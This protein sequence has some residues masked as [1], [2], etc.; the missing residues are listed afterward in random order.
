MTSTQMRILALAAVAAALLAPRQVR[1]QQQ[2][3][4]PPS[5]Y[6]SFHR[7]GPA[8]VYWGFGWSRAV[9]SAGREFPVVS[10]VEANSPATTAG[11][12]VGDT[13][14]AVDGRDTRD[15]GPM[16]R[17]LQPGSRYVLRLRGGGA[18]REVAIVAG[19]PRSAAPT[20]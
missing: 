13:I 18:V 16:F 9:T 20:P 12:A 8:P 1:A 5:G 17:H 10:S 15:D 3:A 14:L 11:L 6:P 19:P 2:S 7:T 4:G